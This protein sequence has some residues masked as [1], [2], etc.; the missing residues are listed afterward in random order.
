MKIKKIL[1]LTLAALFIL[2]AF[3]SCGC[4]HEWKNADCLTPKT[5]TLC[6]ETEGEALG[7]KWLDATCTSAKSCKNCD[8]TDGKPLGHD[9]QEA[10]TEAPT[11]CSVCKV[12]EGKKIDA[13][14]RF[15]T[16]ST[17]AFYGKWTCETTIPAEMFELEGFIEDV[18]CTLSY[19]FKNAGD[20]IADI[21]LDD[22]DAFMDAM[23][24]YTKA[25]LV[26]AL[27]AQGVP[28]AQ[29]DDAMVAAYGMT[30]DEYVTEY[31]DSIDMD[32]LFA[33]FT[34]EYVYYVGQNGIYMADSW[35]SEFECSEYTME[36]DTLIIENDV[37]EEG[38]EPLVCKKVT[39]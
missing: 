32:E 18:P 15:T 5:C 19:E 4:K 13:D 16:E 1:S 27:I 22:Y 24:A 33:A 37:I 38:G 17:K 25:A 26:D 20:V 23:K 11:T 21:E 39:E 14:P 2:C 7:H 29:I 28:E 6:E 36:G 3:S 31:I 10:T 12:T 9:W 35:L 34:S 30:L 8:E